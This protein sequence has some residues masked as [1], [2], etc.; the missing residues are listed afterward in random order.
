MLGYHLGQGLGLGT[1]DFLSVLPGDRLHQLGHHHHTVVGNGGGN[2]RPVQGT[3]T[4]LAHSSGRIG[5]ALLAGFKGGLADL[6]GNLEG[7]RFVKPE[8]LGKTLKPLFPQPSQRHLCKG[9]VAGLGQGGFY[10]YLIP[11]PSWV[12]PP[13]PRSQFPKPPVKSD[14]GFRGNLIFF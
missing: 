8:R 5:N 9:H 14:L 4:H 13:V 12:V 11:I 7:D 3:Q 1:I 10:G 2:H 6:Y